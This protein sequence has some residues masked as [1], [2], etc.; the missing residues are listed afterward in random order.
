M[1]DQWRQKGEFNTWWYA[2]CLAD[3]STLWIN[4]G[5]P[6][7]FY[8]IN[9]SISIHQVVTPTILWWELMVQPNAVNHDRMPI[10]DNGPCVD[11]WGTASQAKMEIYLSF[12]PCLFLGPLTI[13]CSLG[14]RVFATWRSCSE[15]LSLSIK[16]ILSKTID[17]ARRWPDIGIIATATSDS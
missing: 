15:Y 14:L 17:I 12:E 10:Y 5:T 2:H 4:R 7:L 9:T 3:K 1:G 6:T 16:Y 13:F 8:G 11:Y